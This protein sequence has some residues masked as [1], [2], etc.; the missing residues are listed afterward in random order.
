MLH[1]GLRHALGDAVRAADELVP[2]HL[3]S[4][5]Q[6]FEQ[7]LY[8]DTRMFLPDGILICNDKMSM[9]A[10][11]ELRVPFLDVELMRFVERAVSALGS[12][13]NCL[14]LFSADGDYSCRI[15]MLA[16][17]ARITGI[18]RDPDHI[19]RAETIARR[20]AFANVRFRRSDRWCAALRTIPTRS[21]RRGRRSIR[22]TRGFP[23]S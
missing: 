21:S 7:A 14:E 3:K 16:P 23:A 11:L 2:L 13:P 4:S 1:E 12:R 22:S 17:D 19:R 9:S 15:R 18:E 20:L 8:L 6:L 10:S 5:G